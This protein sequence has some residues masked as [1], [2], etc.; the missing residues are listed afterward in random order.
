ML[1]RRATA[2]EKHGANGVTSAVADTRS[3]DD[4]KHFKTP[5]E[6]AAEVDD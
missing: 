6:S 4:T 1:Q 3:F 5:E 2:D